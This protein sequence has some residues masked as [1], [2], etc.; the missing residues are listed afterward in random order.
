MATLTEIFFQKV[1]LQTICLIAND[2]ARFELV[3][4]IDQEQLELLG[5]RLDSTGIIHQKPQNLL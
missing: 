5:A 3:V 1:T 2:L 4:L